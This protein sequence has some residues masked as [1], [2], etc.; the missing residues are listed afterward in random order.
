MPA[1]VLV[2]RPGWKRVPRRRRKPVAAE[3]FAKKVKVEADVRIERCG[4]PSV[5]SGNLYREVEVNAGTAVAAF[6]QHI[7]QR[8]QFVDVDFGRCARTRTLCGM[9]RGASPKGEGNTR[10]VVAAR[11]R[12]PK[13]DRDVVDPS[14]TY[15][16]AQK[17]SA[18]AMQ[19]CGEDLRAKIVAVMRR[20]TPSK[21]RVP[22]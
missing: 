19:R 14:V 12:S 4:S 13:G 5:A 18:D 8:A 2:E 1:E 17:A 10:S 11:R 16:I 6:G 21:Q 7:A 22:P 15:R 9:T 20:L 3:P